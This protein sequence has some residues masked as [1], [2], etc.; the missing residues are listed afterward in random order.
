M[1]QFDSQIQNVSDTSLWVAYYRAKETKR[2]NAL[3]SDPFAERL[4][5]ARGEKIAEQMGTIGRYTEWTVIMR[6]VIIDE[7]IQVMV[8]QGVDTIINLGA[9]LDTRPYRLPLPRELRW[10]EIDFPNIIDHKTKFLNEEHPKCN[11]TRVKLDLTLRNERRSCFTEIRRN[12]KKALVITEGLI[13]Y[14]RKEDVKFLAKDLYEELSFSY[15]IT[16]FLDPA[17]YKYLKIGWRSQKMKNAPFLFF[18]DNWI[19]F[20]EQLGWK[21]KLIR[22]LGEEGIKHNRDFPLPWWASIFKIFFA[23]SISERTKKMAGFIL[24]ERI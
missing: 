12:S 4:I 1:T 9:G 16:E 6:T 2:P 19:L 13:P 21:P 23:R 14:L 17:V 20:F 8:Q 15:W 7:F 11:L 18:P 5:G 22:Y 10:Y 3:F 24:F